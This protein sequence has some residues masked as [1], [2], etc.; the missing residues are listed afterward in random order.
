MG[1]G[2]T[3]ITLGMTNS[4]LIKGE[5]GY[6]LVDAGEP[7]KFKHFKKH[8]DHLG[9]DPHEI[10]LIIITHAHYDHVGCLAQIKAMCDSLVIIH[11]H[12]ARFIEKGRVII[13]PGTNWLGKLFSVVGRWSKYLF[14]FEPVEAELLVDYEFDLTPYGVSGKIIPTP[15]HTPGSISVILDD[16]QGIVGDLAMNFRGQN[17]PIFAEHPEQIYSSWKLIIEKGAKTI[18]PAHGRSFKASKLLEKIK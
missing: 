16:G 5:N 14:S 18:Y 15:G 6:L 3:T 7:C 1:M 11:P 4:Y 12:E 8:L 10:E 9:I 2:V 17:Y 13:P